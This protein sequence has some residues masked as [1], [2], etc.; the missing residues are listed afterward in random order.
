[1]SCRYWLV[2]V[3]D[4]VV[5]GKRRA[6]DDV[7]GQIQSPCNFTEYCSTVLQQHYSTVKTEMVIQVDPLD[8]DSDSD[9]AESCE[10]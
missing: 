1:M 5:L 4:E 6:S 2:Y 8:S 9:S 10:L 3:A 7:M